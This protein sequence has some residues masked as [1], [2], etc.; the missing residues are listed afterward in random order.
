M[1]TP[2]FKHIPDDVVR[3]YREFAAGRPGIV[4]PP[5]LL[6]KLVIFDFIAPIV[7]AHPH[8]SILEIGCGQGI[9]SIL[10]S[11]YGEVSATELAVPGSFIGADRDVGAVREAVFRELADHAVSFAHNDGRRLP[12]GD[13]AFDIVFHNSVIEHVPD[14]IAFNREVRRVL[15]PGGICICI[16]GTPALCRFRLVKDY[17]L[18]LPIHA[19]VAAIR[20]IPLL[21]ELAI[22]LLRVLGAS[23]ET[24]LKARERLLRVDDRVRALTGSA[25]S[26]GTAG[27]CPETGQSKLY[28]RLYH[29]LYFPDYNRVVLEEIS[30]ELGTNAERLLACM[31]KHFGNIG[32]RFRFA[33]TPQTHGQHYRNVWHEM[34]EWRIERWRQQFEQTGFLVEDVLGY[35]YHHLLEITPRPAWNA[36]LYAL[37]VHRIHA[38]L[39]R[40]MFDPSCASEIII[41]AKKGA[42]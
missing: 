39:D 38:V 21:R 9:H 17:F 8:G 19:A 12:Y 40:R 11:R 32:N 18:K 24:R 13:A 16:T 15:K 41:V 20:E 25:S 26:P 6:Q 14:A 1:G 29:F 37:A 27:P 34:R 42:P 22:A 3:R 23:D 30:R 35:R 7:A 31:E 28:P 10:L 5:V 4:P 33:L 36:A 2:R